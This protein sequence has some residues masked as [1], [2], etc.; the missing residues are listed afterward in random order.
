MERQPGE[1]VSNEDTH[2]DYLNKPVNKQTNIHINNSTEIIYENVKKFAD[3]LVNIFTDNSPQLDNINS[4]ESTST[5]LHED[6][7]AMNISPKEMIDS[8]TGTKTEAS[9]GFDGITN[10]VLKNL[11]FNTLCSIH[12]T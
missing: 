12:A 3:N 4:T 10:K 8:L 6:N 1:A 5:Y 9:P 11:P 7:H 2:E